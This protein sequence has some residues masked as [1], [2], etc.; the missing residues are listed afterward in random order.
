MLSGPERLTDLDFADDITLLD[1]IWQGMAYLTTRIEKEAETVGLRI[2]AAKT[3]LMVI[4]K[5]DQEHTCS[6]T[7]GG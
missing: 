5:S 3:K 6:I 2:N 1:T 7:A 4:G